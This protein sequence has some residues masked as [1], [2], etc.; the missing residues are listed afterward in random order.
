MPRVAVV[1]FLL[2]G[3][4]ILLGRRRS[5]VGDS[6]FAL[7]GGHLEF[8]LSL[9]LFIYSVFYSLLSYSLLL[10]FASCWGDLKLIINNISLF[11]VFSSY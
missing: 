9:S 1:V 10:C 6:T 3:K 2:K 7:P 5:S 11:E 8:G 4:A